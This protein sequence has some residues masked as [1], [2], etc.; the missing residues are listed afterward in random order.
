MRYLLVLAVL[1]LASVDAQAAFRP[2]KNLRA[3]VQ[4]RRAQ[5]YEGTVPAVVPQFRPAAK[6]CPDGNCPIRKRAAIDESAP[7]TAIVY[8][9]Q[10]RRMP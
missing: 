7:P 5:R 3:R 10:A 4:E 1:A 6:D 2:L 9:E 8:Y